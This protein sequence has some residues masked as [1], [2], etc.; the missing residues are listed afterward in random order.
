MPSLK[1]LRR[2]IRTVDNTKL[3][4]RA[5]RS[6]AASKMRRTHERR[7]RAKA[8]TERLQALIAR[9]AGSVGGE[10]QPLMER[11]DREKRLLVVFSSDRGLCGA[12]N[13]V[14]IRHANDRLHSLPAGTGI[15]AVGKRAADFFRKHGAQIV[16]S[17][18]DF[19]GNIDI[20]RILAIAKEL[21]ELFLRKEYDVIEL[22]FN[23][24]VTAMTYRPKME[25]LLPLNQ[26]DLL[27]SLGE[28]AA[29][30]P[31]D[32]IFEPDAQ[33]VL[34]QLLPKYLETKVLFTFVNAF[35]AE[36]QARMMAMT[37]ANDNCNEL[38]DSLTLQL[39]KARQSSITKELL[40]IVS[41]AEALKG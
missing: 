16:G 36:H 24:A 11:R 34:A 32:Y 10:G 41:G 17:H 23:H 19:R 38:L 29:G 35:A 33:T 37:T 28:K 6:V 3:I 12:F 39:N 27:R 9:V 2:R 15:Y 25:T 4:T 22:I 5:M 31:I 14:I 18:S 1:Q 21:Q 26:E 30:K 7:A 13:A 40:E 8:Y 20:P